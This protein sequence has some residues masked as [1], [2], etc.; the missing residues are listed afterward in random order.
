MVRCTLYDTYNGEYIY[1]RTYYYHNTV[2]NIKS[3][4]G[5][6]DGNGNHWAWFA[7]NLQLE[8]GESLIQGTRLRVEGV[9]V[10]LWHDVVYGEFPS[11]AAGEIQYGR[12]IRQ[13]AILVTYIRDHVSLVGRFRP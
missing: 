7:W 5:V 4:G 3:L 11:G 6:V 10:P 1:K 9:E 12:D 8:S 13:P 2:H